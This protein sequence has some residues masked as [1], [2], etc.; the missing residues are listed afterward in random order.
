MS[1]SHSSWGWR[2]NE[3]D[4]RPGA[5][6][7]TRKRDGR[8]DADPAPRALS[9][10]GEGCDCSFAA[11][12]LPHRLGAAAKPRRRRTVGESSRDAGKFHVLD[13]APFRIT[14]Y[15]YQRLL[16]PCDSPPNSLGV[17]LHR[18]HAARVLNLRS[19]PSADLRVYGPTCVLRASA[20]VCP[21]RPARPT[22][23]DRG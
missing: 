19:A 17:E 20:S 22:R 5:S 14:P 23:S 21:S 6:Y 2:T 4:S 11:P 1:R 9:T 10:A 13:V 8:G 12:P 3:P 18:S 7:P 16:Q 15:R